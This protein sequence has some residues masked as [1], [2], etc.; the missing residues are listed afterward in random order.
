MPAAT[1]AI[2]NPPK[3]NKHCL[4]EQHLDPVRVAR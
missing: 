2:P 3:I 1:L 4:A